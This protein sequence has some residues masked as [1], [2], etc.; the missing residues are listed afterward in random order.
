[1]KK[2]I[3]IIVGISL[4]FSSCNRKEDSFSSHIEINVK[5]DYDFFDFAVGK[6]GNI[7]ISDKDNY[8][9]RYIMIPACRHGD[10]CLHDHNHE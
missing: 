4:F 5:T 3:F 8:E 2:A 6:N 1:M 9:K 7:Y 10:K